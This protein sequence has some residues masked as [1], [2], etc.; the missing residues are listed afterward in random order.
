[1]K[2]ILSFDIAKGKSIYCFIDD[3]RNTIID[4]TLIEHKKNEFDNLFKLV[5]NYHNLI[6]I[7]ESTSVYHLPVENY[8]RSKGIDTIVINPKL[9][10]QFKD[11]LNK[12]KTDKL[13]CFKIAR[14]YLGTIDN[15]YY[16][17]D[18]TNPI[19]LFFRK[20]YY[21]EKIKEVLLTNKKKYHTPL[22]GIK[23]IIL[24]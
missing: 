15:F 10:K 20:K 22:L 6:V 1:M 4:A 7:M 5:K 14:C 19:Y 23:I 3:L 24:R 13:D 18:K 12:S 8:F 11:T 9:V 16:K 17:S 21:K 2:H